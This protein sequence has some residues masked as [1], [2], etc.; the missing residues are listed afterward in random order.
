MRIEIDLACRPHVAPAELQIVDGR[1]V[2]LEVVIVVMCSAPWDRRMVLV[3]AVDQA[4]E[5]AHSL[6]RSVG[7]SPLKQRIVVVD[8]ESSFE[9]IVGT[10]GEAV[11]VAR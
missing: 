10:D 9:R 4:A 11:E 1:I 8:P 2:D 5:V 6:R 3:A 7:H